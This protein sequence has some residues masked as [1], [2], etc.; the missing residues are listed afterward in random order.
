METWRGK[1]RL[2]TP[3]MT[4]EITNAIK[5]LTVGAGIGMQTFYSSW[6]FAHYITIVMLRNVV[7]NIKVG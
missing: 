3:Q 7:K 4:E 1:L 2:E 5:D 6:I